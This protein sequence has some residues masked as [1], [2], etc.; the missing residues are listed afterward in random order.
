MTVSRLVSAVTLCMVWMAVSSH[1][2]PSEEDSLHTFLDA[3]CGIYSNKDAAAYRSLFHPVASVAYINGDGTV[4]VMELAEFMETQVQYFQQRKFVRESFENI[5]MEIDGNAASATADYTLVDETR[6]I[7]GTD[8][9]SLIKENGR[10]R[11]I[12]LLFTVTSRTLLYSGKTEAEPENDIR[13]KGEFRTRV[14]H[15]RSD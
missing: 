10:W 8:F 1:G 4:T 13:V 15:K 5:R 2:A 14:Y 6:E 9:F 12:S 3:Y 11:I 7:N